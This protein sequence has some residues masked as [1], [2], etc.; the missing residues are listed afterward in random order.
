MKLCEGIVP[1]CQGTLITALIQTFFTVHET[2]PKRSCVKNA[3]VFEAEMAPM[4][5]LKGLSV[6]WKADRSERSGNQLEN[7]STKLCFGWRKLNWSH[8][9]WTEWKGLK[10]SFWYIIE[11]ETISESSTLQQTILFKENTFILKTSPVLAQL[12]RNTP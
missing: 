10:Q 9:A 11:I 4:W 3:V 12:W 6:P 1:L 8:P 2:R 5:T 7:G